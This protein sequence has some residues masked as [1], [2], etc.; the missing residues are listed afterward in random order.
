MAGVGAKK[1]VDEKLDQ[2][3]V[4]LF[5]KTYSPESQS[6]LKLLEDYNMK[7]P[8]FEVINIETRQD[9]NQIE[10]YFQ[11]KCLTDRREVYLSIYM[12]LSVYLSICLSIYLHDRSICLL[13]KVNNFARIQS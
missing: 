5:S 3:K 1:F 4:L 13:N 12:C 8:T 7:H 6:V 2:R 10:N 9:C 11:I